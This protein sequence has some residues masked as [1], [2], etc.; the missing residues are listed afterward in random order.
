VALTGLTPNTHE[1]YTVALSNP[2]GGPVTTST[3]AF[4]TQP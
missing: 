3:Q 2:A 1:N 4:T